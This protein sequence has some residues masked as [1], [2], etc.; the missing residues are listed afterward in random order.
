MSPEA[1]ELLTEIVVPIIA[2]TVPAKVRTVGVTTYTIAWPRQTM[3]RHNWRDERAT[4]A[5]PNVIAMTASAPYFGRLPK[6][7]K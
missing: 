3:I 6:G 5:K 4:G 1:G 2:A 7:E